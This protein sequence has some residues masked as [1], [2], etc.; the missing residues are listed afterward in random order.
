MFDFFHGCWNVL[1]SRPRPRD[2]FKRG[3][4]LELL[5][6]P[7]DWRQKNI[8]AR[9]TIH[10]NRILQLSHNLVKGC[11]THRIYLYL[12]AAGDSLWIHYVTV[13]VNLKT[14]TV[15]QEAGTQAPVFQ[16]VISSFSACWRDLACHVICY[17]V[18]WL[19]SSRCL[20]RWLC[21]ENMHRLTWSCLL[22]P[23]Q[24]QACWLHQFVVRAEQ[25]SCLARQKQQQRMTALHCVPERLI[26]VKEAEKLRTKLRLEAF[27]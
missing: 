8:P 21:P 6:L 11:D 13:G 15:Y 5:I 1:V 4:A 22:W 19:I 25:K 9:Q 24:T 16:L 10:L 27:V 17:D 3:F 20:L 2:C 12:L 14:H 18:L 23:L 7:V 26:G